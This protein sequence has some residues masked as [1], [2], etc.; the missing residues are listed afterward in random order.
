[1]VDF[2]EI[3]WGGNAIEDDLDA[4]IFNAVAA[5][6]PKWRKLTLLR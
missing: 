3:Q 5:V 1:L 6:I 4:M 2:C